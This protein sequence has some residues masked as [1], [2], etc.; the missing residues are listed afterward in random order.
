M[1]YINSHFNYLR[2]YLLTFSA[3]FHIAP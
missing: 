2:T 1:R 3:S